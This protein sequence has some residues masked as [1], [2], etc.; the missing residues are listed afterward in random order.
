M[1]GI[2]DLNQK[3]SDLTDEQITQLQMAKIKKESPGLYKLLT[4]QQ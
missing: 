2:A 4:Q 3:V 1:A